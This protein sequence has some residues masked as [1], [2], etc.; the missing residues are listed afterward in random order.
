MGIKK[1]EGSTPAVWAYIQALEN[2]SEKLA[3]RVKELEE[4]LAKVKEQGAQDG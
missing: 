4:Q 2:R 3:R 1:N